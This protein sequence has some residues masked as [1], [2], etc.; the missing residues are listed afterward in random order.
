MV[1]GDQPLVITSKH[2]V[3]NTVTAPDDYLSLIQP[4]EEV[5]AQK[6]TNTYYSTI[7]LTKTMKDGEQTKL[8]SKEEKLTQIVITESIPPK[9]ASIMTSYV[10]YDVEDSNSSSTTDIV[11]TFYVTYTYYNTLVENG[12]IVV[13]TN[14]ST[15]KDFSTQKLYVQDNELT[16]DNV[17]IIATKTYQTTFTYFTTLLQENN[18]ATPTVVS[19]HSKVVENIATET[20]HPKQLNENYW[21]MLKYELKNVKD[22]IKETVLLNDGQR[23]EVTAYKKPIEPTKVL[24]IQMTNQPTLP[25]TEKPNT[26]QSN[27]NVITGSTIIFFDDDPFASTSPTPT[28]NVQS[29]SKNKAS[30]NSEIIK[31]TQIQTSSSKIKKSKTQNIK[32]TK[33]VTPSRPI[34]KVEN[35]KKKQVTKL[36][37]P[38]IAETVS[39]NSD[40]LGLGSINIESLKALTPVINAM[41]GL[42]KTNLKPKKKNTTETT[43]NSKTNKNN[44]QSYTDDNQNRSPIYIPV[45]DLEVSESQNIGNYY[46]HNVVDIGG[47]KVNFKKPT[48]ETPLLN[49]GIPISPGE[50][51]TANSDVIVG[52]PGRILP[53]VPP[54]PVNEKHVT[55]ITD[56]NPPP[57]TNIRPN[58]MPIPVNH[59]EISTSG[60][61]NKD[62]YVGPPPPITGKPYARGEK[63][64]HIP[65]HHS[66]D[67]YHQR[68]VQQY[69]H[70]NQAHL[71][72]YQNHQYNN[73]K[74]HGD[75]VRQP[76]VQIEILKKYE[77][78]SKDNVPI[79][80]QRAPVLNYNDNIQGSIIKEPMVLPEV[81]ERSTG[82]PLLVNIQPSQVAFVNIPHNRTTA[83]IYGGSTE[84]HRYGQ[85][86][87]D[88]SPHS[89]SDNAV[90]ENIN[91]V[92]QYTAGYHMNSNQKQVKGVIKVGTQAINVQPDNPNSRIE[93]IHTTKPQDSFA[94]GN[95][96]EI[97]VHVPPISF[98]M[99]QNE[100]DFNAHVINHGNDLK[101]QLPP[102]AYEVTKANSKNDNYEPINYNNNSYK[103]TMLQPINTQSFP[104]KDQDYNKEIRNK[105]PT[106]NNINSNTQHQAIYYMNHSLSSNQRRLNRTKTKLQMKNPGN[107]PVQSY[108]GQGV[109]LADYMIPP[110]LK[111]KQSKPVPFH[112]KYTNRPHTNRPYPQGQNSQQKYIPHTNSNRINNTNS[113]RYE[114]SYV[115]DLLSSD[116]DLV[117]SDGEVI[118]ETNSRPLRPGEVPHEILNLKT[119]PSPV[120]NNHT[121]ASKN[122]Y[123]HPY[124]N[125]LHEIQ[126]P[127]IEDPRPFVRPTK[128]PSNDFNYS[129]DFANNSFNRNDIKNL[130]KDEI[131]RYDPKV[132]SNTYK[133]NFGS[134]S[135]NSYQNRPH[136][137][138]QTPENR[139]ESS[140]KAPTRNN[141]PVVTS[142]PIDSQKEQ[143]EKPVIVDGIKSTQTEQ[144]FQGK[145]VQYIFDEKTSVKTPIIREEIHRNSNNN[146]FESNKREQVI[147]KEEQSDM[148]I[149][150]P[151]PLSPTQ[152]SFLKVTPTA[153]PTEII[154][155]PTDPNMKRVPVFNAATVPQPVEEMKPPPVTTPEREIIG[156]S[157]PPITT[158]KPLLKIK[159]K[160]PTSRP[161][162]PSQI[163]NLKEPIQQI[164]RISTTTTRPIK[165]RTRRPYPPRRTLKTTVGTTHKPFTKVPRPV[166]NVVN[167]TTTSSFS[168]TQATTRITTSKRKSTTID[169][170]RSLEEDKSDSREGVLI[171]GIR[172]PNISYFET[173]T[174]AHKDFHPNVELT[175]Y[176]SEKKE[177][178]IRGTVEKEIIGATKISKPIPILPSKIEKTGLR[179]LPTKFI[180]HTHTM[181]VTITKTTVLKTPGLPPVTSTILVTKT[182]KSTIVDTV[183]EFHTLL[184]PTS[185]VETITTTVQHGSL[186]PPDVYG[187][188]YPSIQIQPTETIIGQIVTPTASDMSEESL[189]EFI[190]TD[191]DPPH[192]SNESQISMED[193]DTIFVVMTDKK[194]GTILKVPPVE[195]IQSRDEMLNTNKLNDV[196]VAG[197]LSANPPSIDTDAPM[198]TDRCAPE[199]KASRNE[200]CQ[201]TNGLMRCVC[202]PGFARMFL[203]RPCNRKFKNISMGIHISTSNAEMRLFI[204][205]IFRNTQISYFHSNLHIL[206]GD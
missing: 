49:G 142:L 113:N 51:I 196:L 199:C 87:D 71:Q 81:I 173:T 103:Y 98:G 119:T 97:N 172:R 66:E 65:L 136:L 179:I 73:G 195:E 174:S 17:V 175:G 127:V 75:N 169:P 123:K 4:S 185:V 146:Y 128:N 111:P 187:Q 50:V 82:Q 52:K 178:L 201:K 55:E 110:T 85:Y 68:Y 122:I 114:S 1:D 177:V 102:I 203:D 145:P 37:K 194:H 168:T 18:K 96:Q 2:T 23:L 124:E 67:H 106:N 120:W 131:V 107:N 74:K 200:L 84:P 152:N 53:R 158:Y 147:P 188:P 79:Y 116:Y 204:L 10:A 22:E 48:H 11:K 130:L 27:P 163:N 89:G 60:G 26:D 56:M 93:N 167:Y 35:S 193:N 7:M 101:V 143:T 155:E 45:G 46:H 57:V 135:D 157:P 160:I 180:T 43:T 25:S 205:D 44:I 112:N 34:K 78:I 154:L 198:V 132:E 14:I 153:K 61:R 162:I 137:K 64:K 3:T 86:F 176:G 115:N 105:S 134:L 58:P 92:I 121:S 5:I 88:P 100:N 95:N 54:I 28:L 32:P 181:T 13:H 20:I 150:K 69:N 12:K 83:L 165:I 42:I 133:P 138:P 16:P 149:L 72:N 159:L 30:I 59:D 125:E 161:I 29:S 186:Y 9:A 94:I 90:N 40:L 170:Y 41:A 33:S 184:K 148:E 47:N 36:P 189:E 182:E 141:R 6:D 21:K 191:T 171:S 126:A 139:R 63:H 76:S 77:Q 91:N 15:S 31:K 197:V 104:K 99:F 39:T 80:T 8:V 19:S 129:T 166:H 151:P 144:P 24:P 108:K 190:I 118:Q 202:R 156:M 109:T 62:D 192:T 117:S 206:F 183:T 164:Q 70:V 38:E 140:T